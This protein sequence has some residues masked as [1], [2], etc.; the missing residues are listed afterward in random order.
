MSAGVYQGAIWTF[1]L[2]L[3]RGKLHATG[4]QMGIASAAPAIGYL[5]ALFWA[6]QM[7]GKSKLPF[8]TITWLLSR[9]MFCLT[10]L[11]VRGAFATEWFLMLICLTPILFSVSAPA[12]TSIMKEI[13]PD[14]HRGRL[15][16]YVRIGMA[17]T[18]LI[19]AR[20][21][22]V[23]QEHYGLDYR[24]MF[25]FGG[26]FGILT[27]YAFFRLRLAPPLPSEG[28][29]PSLG[30]FFK[31]TF[32]ILRRNR[33][34]RFFTI[35]VIL[36]GFGNL[37]ANTYYPVYQVD[38]FHIT[39]TQIATLQNVGGILSL[40]SLFF[41]GWFL[42]RFGSLTCVLA[43]VLLNCCTP[44]MYAMAPH[45]GW[46]Y[47]GSALQSAA[48]SGVDLGY[49]NTT[50]SLSEP[51]RAAQYQSLHSFFFGLRGTIAPLI[52]FPL[53]GVLGGVWGR[54]FWLC[55]FVMLAGVLFQ[56]FA[57]RSAR[58]EQRGN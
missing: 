32:G 8:V 5:F 24:W 27:A 10:P 41:W 23:L 1:A 19:S 52:A 33:Q 26:V 4:L 34:Y 13:Y 2:Q 7:E 46:L 45:I 57:L 14:E 11:L 40:I 39:P 43:A 56:S 51:G 47:L 12:Y 28:E 17:A 6:R 18:M 44:A 15:M 38:E 50:L 20:V 29:K 16:S 3:A 53:L 49:L 9:G 55:F 54:G 30:E 31:D 58:T 25:A 42:D 37:L 36:S 35:S 22:G 21:M 48:Q